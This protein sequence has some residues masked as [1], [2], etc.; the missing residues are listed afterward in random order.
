MLFA[1]GRIEHGGT[2]PTHMIEQLKVEMW[3]RFYPKKRFSSIEWL[4]AWPEH[5]SLTGKFH[6][7]CVLFPEDKSGTQGGPVWALRASL[8][9]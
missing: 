5:C 7:Q 2:L 1:V 9:F 6:M 4:D 8:I 3:K